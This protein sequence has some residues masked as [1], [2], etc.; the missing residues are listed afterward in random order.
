[1]VD[2]LKSQIIK[3]THGD[4]TDF[5]EGCIFFLKDMLENAEMFAEQE[6]SQAKPTDPGLVEEL[7]ELDDLVCQCMKE[8]DGMDISKMPKLVKGYREI[9]VK[10]NKIISRYTP[11]GLRVF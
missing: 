6:K 8:W 10:V 7:H 1:M 5:G 2:V 9:F 11:S 4:L 3:T